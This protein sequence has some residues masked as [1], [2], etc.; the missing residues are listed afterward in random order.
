MPLEG[1]HPLHRGVGGG[2]GGAES[3]AAGSRQPTREDPVPMGSLR[4]HA[5]PTYPPIATH[6]RRADGGRMTFTPARLRR[7]RPPA[8]RGA[9]PR[10]APVRSPDPPA[11]VIS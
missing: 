9:R 4:I 6:A 11:E 7:P 2:G 1:I 3:G 5:Q 8:R 10:A